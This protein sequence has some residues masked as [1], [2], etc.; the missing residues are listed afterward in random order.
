MNSAATFAALVD[1]DGRAIPAQ[2]SCHEIDHV[3]AGC[4][5]GNSAIKLVLRQANVPQLRMFRFEAI[6]TPAATIRA[7]DDTTAL[8]VFRNNMW[9][10]W[11][12]IDQGDT[13]GGEALPIGATA[14]R[15]ADPR[16]VDFLVGALVAALED[17]G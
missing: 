5:L 1:T 8:R 3:I 16:T 15:L 9:S 11:F 7:G 12:W 10:E 17:S 4:D 6:Y 14:E 2:V 13:A